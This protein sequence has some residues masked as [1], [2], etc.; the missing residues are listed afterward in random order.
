MSDHRAKRRR[1][2]EEDEEDADN[3]VHNSS[4]EEAV[5]VNDVEEAEPSEDE[6]EDLLEN[7]EA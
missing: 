6:G 3:Q 7:L 1:I 4:D 5:E 2:V